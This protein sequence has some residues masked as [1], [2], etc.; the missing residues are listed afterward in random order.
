MDLMNPC[1]RLKKL[2]LD[3]PSSKVVKKAVKI[4]NQYFYS[5]DPPYD[6]ELI[7]DDL[8]I[9]KNIIESYEF[10]QKYPEFFV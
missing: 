10:R 9:V 7:Y 2:L 6:K 3:K 4:I 5:S 1:L 8:I